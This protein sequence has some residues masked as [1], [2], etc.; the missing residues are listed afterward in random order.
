MAGGN[1]DFA[2]FGH[3]IPL[4]R[5]VMHSQDRTQKGEASTLTRRF[6]SEKLLIYA[7]IM[8]LSKVSDA[9]GLRESA[10]CEIL[11]TT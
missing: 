7:V 1:F 10:C 5:K 11:L 6:I 4:D 2:D 3:E 9:C 8:Y